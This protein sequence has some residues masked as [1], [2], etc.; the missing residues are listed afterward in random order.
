MIA[1]IRFQTGLLLRSNRWLGP[2]LIYAVFVLFSGI[3]GSG[4]QPLNDGLDWSDALLVPSVAWLTRSALTM[5]P[6]AAWACTAA[7]GGPYRAH[8]AALAA[9]LAGGIVLALGG[10]GCQLAV[11]DWPAGGT[12]ALI[13]VI[14]IGLVTAAICLAVGSAVGAFFNPPV[15]RKMGIAVLSMIGAVILALVSGVSPAN[16]ALRQI[17]SPSNSAAWPGVCPVLVAALLLAASWAISTALAARRR[18]LTS[19]DDG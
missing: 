14:A 16:A 4:G 8:L 6:P 2:L 7:A 1:L 11:D 9:A 12:T 3:G 13:K 15:V 5:E 17:R 19:G 10:A 18:A